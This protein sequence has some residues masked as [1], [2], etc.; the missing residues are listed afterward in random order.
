M[1]EKNRGSMRKK[2]VAWCL[3]LMLAGLNACTYQDRVAP[4]RL[5]GAENSV[6]VGG[7][8]KIA[9]RAYTDPAEAE[10][11]FGF[12]ARKAGLLPVQVTFQNDSDDDVLVNPDQT[13]LIDRNNNAWPVLSLEKAFQRTEG[14]VEVGETVK[15]AGKPA[16]LLGAAGAIAGAAIGIL[17]G[18]NVGEAMGKGAVAGAASGAVIGGA[19]SYA[20]SGRRIRDDLA[21]KTLRNETILPHQIAYGVLFFPGVPGDEADGAVELRLGLTM[22]DKPMVVPVM[23]HAQ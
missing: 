10:K 20:S 5:P 9:A 22:G 1:Y 8:L 3:V 6:V 12:N 23:L 11:A 14:H 2:A 18:E 15:G 13:L 4:I 16:L 21:A 19:G 17:T 7:G